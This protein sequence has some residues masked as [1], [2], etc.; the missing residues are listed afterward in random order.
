MANSRC[1]YKR[2]P[3]ALS[4]LKGFFSLLLL[5]GIGLPPISAEIGGGSMLMMGQAERLIQSLRLVPSL[6]S[7]HGASPGGF[8]GYSN[9][10]PSLF[11]RKLDLSVLG[12][13]GSFVSNEELGH[14][15]GYF[16][17]KDTYASRYDV[18]STVPCCHA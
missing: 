3:L 13:S 10:G 9:V 17:L 6:P 16:Q 18:Q 12:G 5:Q 14:H 11:E 1:S 15:A 2:L 7:P 8:D 4:I